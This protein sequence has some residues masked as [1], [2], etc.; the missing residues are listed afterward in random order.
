MVISRWMRVFFRDWIIKEFFPGEVFFQ[1]AF[2]NSCLCEMDSILSFFW[3]FFKILPNPKLFKSLRNSRTKST[4]GH[5]QKDLGVHK[6]FID[7][8]FKNPNSKMKNELIKPVGL[9]KNPTVAEFWGKKEPYQLQQ[10]G[11]LLVGCNDEDDIDCHQWL[12]GGVSFGFWRYWNFKLCLCAGATGSCFLWSCCCRKDILQTPM[13][14]K[15]RIMGDLEKHERA[16]RGN[17]LKRHGGSM[18]ICL[19]W[20]LIFFFNLILTNSFCYDASKDISKI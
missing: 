17:F 3:E 9:V 11:L 10:L 19:I 13:Q 15:R 5:S 1:S 14:K 18:A 8:L 16:H 7:V 6:I 4:T 12:M 2:E 20:K